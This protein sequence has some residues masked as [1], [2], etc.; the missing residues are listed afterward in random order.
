[1]AF[2]TSVLVKYVSLVDRIK[3]FFLPRLQNYL[4]LM[5]IKFFALGN[6]EFFRPMG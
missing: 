1:M 2:L 3:I 4:I 6:N 5:E